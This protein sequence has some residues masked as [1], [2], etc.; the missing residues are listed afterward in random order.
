LPRTWG[1]RAYEHGCFVRTRFSN[2]DSNQRSITDRSYLLFQH[3]QPCVGNHKPMLARFSAALIRDREGKRAM[4]L[5]ALIAVGWQICSSGY[6]LTVKSRRLRSITKRRLRRYW[7]GLHYAR[8]AQQ[9][10]PAEARRRPRQ[11]KRFDVRSAEIEAE[12]WKLRPSARRKTS[13]DSP[14]PNGRTKRRSA[15]RQKAARTRL[16]S[17]NRWQG[18]RAAAYECKRGRK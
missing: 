5:I 7:P 9:M 3:Q 10:R 8:V 4:P 2:N 18:T 14:G 15:K 17:G 11:E 12:V 6:F 13:G 16:S 1:L